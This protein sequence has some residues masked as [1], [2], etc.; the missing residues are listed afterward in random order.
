MRRQ[1]SKGGACLIAVYSRQTDPPPPRSEDSIR[2]DLSTDRPTWPLSSYGGK[3]DPCLIAGIDVSPEE[4]RWRYVQAVKTGT[5]D[6]Y[7]S[8][9]WLRGEE[10]RL[11]A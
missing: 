10:G 1:Y 8:R 3:E 2:L 4:L 5:V 9:V 7:V 6:A 11:T